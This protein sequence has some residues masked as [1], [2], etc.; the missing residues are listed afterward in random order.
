MAAATTAAATVA[1]TA[2]GWMVEVEQAE[3]ATAQAA[4]VWAE[5]GDG[6]GWR[7]WRG[8]G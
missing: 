3:E 1:E 4:L 8:L 2:G 7:R 6:R 5:V